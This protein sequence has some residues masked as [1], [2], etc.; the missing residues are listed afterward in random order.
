MVDKMFDDFKDTKAII[1]DMRGYPNGMAW[2]I[3]PQS[4]P[5]ENCVCC[6]LQKILTY[7][8]AGR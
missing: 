8:H 2:T 5:K 7:E 6:Q 3:A 4:Y 1:F